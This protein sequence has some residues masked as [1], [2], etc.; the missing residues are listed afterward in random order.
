MGYLAG[1]GPG[2]PA[3]KRVFWT[4]GDVFAIKLLDQP[5]L[6]GR[7]RHIISLTKLLPTDERGKVVSL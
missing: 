7:N 2:V 1:F 4:L 5:S 3:K 6:E